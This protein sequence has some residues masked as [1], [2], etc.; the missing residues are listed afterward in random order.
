MKGFLSVYNASQRHDLSVRYL[1]VL[2]S[3]GRI[4]GEQEQISKRHSVWFIEEKSL[5]RFLRTKRSPGRPK[6]KP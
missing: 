2:L 1:R 5:Q 4:K 6:K 3:S